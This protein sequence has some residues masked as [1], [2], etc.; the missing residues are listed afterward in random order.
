MLELSLKNGLIFRSICRA[1]AL[2]FFKTT[3]SAAQTCLYAALDVNL[4]NFRG[5]Y[6]AYVSKD[7]DNV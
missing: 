2:L 7:F 5:E 3:E 1:I 4:L 6:F